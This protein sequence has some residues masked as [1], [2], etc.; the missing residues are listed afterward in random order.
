MTHHHGA[1]WNKRYASAERLFSASA[2]ETLMALT[3]ELEPGRAVDLGAGEGRNSL[4]LAR[5][6]W[7]VTA[8]DFADVALRRLADT[9]SA[10]DL[11]VS[12]VVADMTEYLRGGHLFDLVV[13]SFIHPTPSERADLLAA[14]AAAVA[15]G[16][17]LFLLGHHLDSLG[18]GGPPDPDRLYTADRLDGAFPGLKV[19]R[20]EDRERAAGDTG[21]ALTD[22]VV[23]AERPVAAGVQP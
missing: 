20:L 1:E 23:W 21:Q 4:W 7:Q 8:V 19:L 15:P 17:H 12:T 13:M 22:I 10:D 11:P 6:G 16:G 9:A 5:Q 18:H 3:S 2:D 14:A